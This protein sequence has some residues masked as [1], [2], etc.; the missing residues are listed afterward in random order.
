MPPAKAP[1]RRDGQCAISTGTVM[2]RRM[3]RVPVPWLMKG[4]F[5]G[6]WAPM[7][8]RSTLESLMLLSMA[9]ITPSCSSTV[10]YTHLTLPTILRV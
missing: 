7:I 3:K 8:S 6:V 9:S 10:S 1:V 5:V 2:C 4:R